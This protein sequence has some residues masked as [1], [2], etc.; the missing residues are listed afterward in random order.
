MKKQE[1]H[2]ID[3]QI[4][5]C[6]WVLTTLIQVQAWMASSRLESTTHEVLHRQAE[7]MAAIL[8]TLRKVKDEQSGMEPMALGAAH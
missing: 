1:P 3:A 8:E 7:I 2:S 6:T 5:Y 4:E